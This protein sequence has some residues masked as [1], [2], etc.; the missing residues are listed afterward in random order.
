[1]WYQYR[2]TV[3]FQCL[4]TFTTTTKLTHLHA[5]TRTHACTHTHTLTHSHTLQSTGGDFDRVFITKV[6]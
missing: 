1:M 2:T 6:A 3:S 5:H 4:F